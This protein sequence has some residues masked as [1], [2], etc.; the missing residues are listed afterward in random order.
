MN[1]VVDA[2]VI[3]SVLISSE[4]KTTE[5]FFSTSMRLYAPEFLFEEIEK[6]KGEILRKSG[7]TEVDFNLALAIIKS[8]IRIIPSS[9]F[10]SHVADAERT[11]PDPND[12]EYFALAL[13]L[14]CPIWS[15]DKKLAEQELVTI[16]STTELLKKSNFDFQ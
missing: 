10:S 5:L 7:L 15:N 16:V 8:R 2:N 4:G 1:F 11:C 13:S 3:F 9:E 6:Y 12:R 14:D